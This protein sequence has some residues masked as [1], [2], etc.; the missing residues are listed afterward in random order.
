VF[1]MR[2]SNPD[3]AT[4]IE[5]RIDEFAL[6]EVPEERGALK[7]LGQVIDM[8]EARRRQGEDWTIA[9]EYVRSLVQRLA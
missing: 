4:V 2:S 3:L 8:Q 9:K 1:S 5:R 7:R 6:N